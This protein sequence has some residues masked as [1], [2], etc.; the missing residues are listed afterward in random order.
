MNLE[1]FKGLLDQ[2][3]KV[4][5][6]ALRVLDLVADVGVVSFEKVQNGEDLTVVRHE[7]FTDGVGAGDER[8]QDFQSDG[9]DLCVT[10]VQS[11]LDRND[12]L[13][14][15]WEHLGATLLKH[16]EDTLNGKETV[17]VSLLTDTLKEDGQVVMVVELHD[18]DLPENRVALTV[19]N[20]DGEVT[21]VVETSEFTG[22]DQ[23]LVPGT[24]NWLS[25]K[26]LLLGLV[27]RG[28]FTTEATTTL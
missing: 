27:Q 19:L 8:L 2:V 3:T 11:S 16:I 12:K 22:S 7:S 24:S 13:R 14:D 26:G 21:S 17:W 5:I 10:G 23:T 18:I 9:N 15:D 20:G 25:D 28:N 6:F 4:Q 1:K